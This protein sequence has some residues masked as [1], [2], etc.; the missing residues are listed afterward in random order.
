MNK[1]KTSMKDLAVWMRDCPFPVENIVLSPDE[2]QIEVILSYPQ[3]S[4]SYEYTKG[5]IELRVM[6]AFDE[7]IN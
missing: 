7:T 5:E 2:E 3:D 1:P 4:E 6:E